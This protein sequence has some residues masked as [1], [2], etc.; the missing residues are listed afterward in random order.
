LWWKFGGERA[1]G[2]M[3]ENLEANRLS[4]SPVFRSSE[5]SEIA[6]SAVICTYNQYELLPAAIEPLAKQDLPARLVGIS[7]SRAWR[8][9]G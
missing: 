2:G 9:A 7:A 3:R 5:R 8:E 1:A 6:L 4:G